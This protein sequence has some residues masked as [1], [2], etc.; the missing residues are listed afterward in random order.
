MWVRKIHE[1]LEQDYKQFFFADNDTTTLTK[2]QIFSVPIN[3]LH[4]D[5]CYILIIK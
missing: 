3:D 4:I 5:T 1:D 2:I